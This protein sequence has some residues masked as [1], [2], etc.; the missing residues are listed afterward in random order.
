[1]T[2]LRCKSLKSYFPNDVASMAWG[3]TLP[4]LVPSSCQEWTIK[5]Y[6]HYV[7]TA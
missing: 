6:K 5:N 4:N 1:M 3:L 7:N 2:T